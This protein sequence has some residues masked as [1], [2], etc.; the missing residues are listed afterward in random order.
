MGV[1]NPPLPFSELKLLERG[2]LGKRQGTATQIIINFGRMLMAT[3][4]NVHPYL[5]VQLKC[6]HVRSYEPYYFMATPNTREE[7][8]CGD[9]VFLAC[10]VTQ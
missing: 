10:T 6:F 8:I 2:G 3:K 4:I 1:F 5:G 9:K 7:V